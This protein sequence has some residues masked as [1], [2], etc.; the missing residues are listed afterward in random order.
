MAAAA[1]SGR[2]R[3]RLS[4]AEV[5]AAWRKWQ[6]RGGGGVATEAL[7]RLCSN[8]SGSAA[9]GRAKPPQPLPAV[10]LASGQAPSANAN[11]LKEE[12]R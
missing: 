10:D 2:G 7:R 5:T 1:T 6:Q 3:R 4:K 11:T 9:A 8:G 12:P